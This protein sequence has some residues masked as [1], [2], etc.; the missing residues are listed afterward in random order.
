MKLSRT[1]KSKPHQGTHLPAIPMIP[2]VGPI[3]P[4]AIDMWITATCI[5]I[6]CEMLNRNTNWSPELNLPLHLHTIKCL[7]LHPLCVPFVVLY[8]IRVHPWFYTHS[9][10]FVSHEKSRMVQFVVKKYPVNPAEGPP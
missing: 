3:S 4:G 7:I 10:S 8:S 9:C 1:H 2:K 5:W 6:S